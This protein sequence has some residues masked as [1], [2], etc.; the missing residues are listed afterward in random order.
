MPHCSTRFARV[1]YDFTQGNDNELRIRTRPRQVTV[2][3]SLLPLSPHQ[4]DQ[5]QSAWRLAPLLG[6]DKLTQKKVP[7]IIYSLTTGPATFIFLRMNPDPERAGSGSWHRLFVL[8][9]AVN[10]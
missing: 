9:F 1:H 5:P 7:S 3:S 10:D 4:H 8:Q 2:F 6:L